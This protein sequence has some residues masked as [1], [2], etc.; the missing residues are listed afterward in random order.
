[1]LG[2]IDSSLF[3]GEVQFDMV[4]VRPEL[5]MRGISKQLAKRTLDEIRKFDPAA[6]LKESDVMTDEGAAF[7]KSIGSRVKAAQF[8]DLRKAAL[9]LIED[10]PAWKSL[11]KAPDSAQAYGNMQQALRDARSEEELQAAWEAHMD[12]PWEAVVAEAGGRKKP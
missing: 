3:D 4:W 6:Q 2:Y 11:I 7:H 10:D 1:V 12:M 9:R 5:R 8:D